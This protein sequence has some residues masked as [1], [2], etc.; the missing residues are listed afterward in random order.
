LLNGRAVGAAS[1]QQWDVKRVGDRVRSVGERYSA[2]QRKEDVLVF[3]VGVA[4]NC[5]E[6]ARTGTRASRP[7]LCIRKPNK[8]GRNAKTYWRTF[9][10]T[11]WCSVQTCSVLLRTEAGGTP[12]FQSVAASRRTYDFSQG[13]ALCYG[14]VA[15]LGRKKIRR[16]VRQSISFVA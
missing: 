2:H 9:A 13:V 11:F 14:L 3:L 16:N 5:R 8:F 7:P 15:P 1:R 4:D 12:A 10:N 6:A